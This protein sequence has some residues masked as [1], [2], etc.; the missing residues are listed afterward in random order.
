[1]E[2]ATYFPSQTESTGPSDRRVK[3]KAIRRPVFSERPAPQ[4]QLATAAEECWRMVDEFDWSKTT[5]GPRA[6]WADAVDPLLAVVFNSKTED[7][8]WLGDDLQIL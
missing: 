6:D 5:L 7:S 1:M 2:S 4:Y 8:L 3:P